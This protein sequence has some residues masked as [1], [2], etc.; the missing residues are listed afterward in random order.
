MPFFRA[1][2]LDF[3]SGH[4]PEVVIRESE[5]R[6]YGIRAADILKLEIGGKTFFVGVDYTYN[7]VQEGEIGLFK[8]V[9][10]NSR[11]KDGKILMKELIIIKLFKNLNEKESLDKEK[12]S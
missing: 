6:R 12:E 10:E 4:R 11:I 8:E 3:A 1:K 7:K 9:W 2:K 5:A